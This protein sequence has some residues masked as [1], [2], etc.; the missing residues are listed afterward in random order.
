MNNNDFIFP[1]SEMVSRFC[2]PN[3]DWKSNKTDYETC[4]LPKFKVLFEQV[5]SEGD[6]DGQVIILT[7]ICLNSHYNGN[8]WLWF[9]PSNFLTCVPIVYI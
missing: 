5:F 6:E 1:Q 2:L 4:I 3:G 9:Y 7:I 8:T